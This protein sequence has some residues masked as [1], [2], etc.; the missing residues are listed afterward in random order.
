MKNKTM[1]VNFNCLYFLGSLILSFSIYADEKKDLLMVYEE[2]VLNDPLLSSAR[3]LNQSTKELIDQGLSLFLPNINIDASYDKNDNKRKILT[4]GI[5]NDLLS[6]TSAN[7]ESYDYGVTITQPIFNYASYAKYKQNLIQSSLS[8]KQLIK[9]QQNLIF[10]VLNIYFETLMAMDNIQLLQA[11]YSAIKAQLA[12]ADA[13]FEL[14]LI[15]ITDV[16][17]A[18]TKEALLKI[19]KIDAIQKL[20][21]K[22]REIESITGILPGK[23][24]PLNSIITFTKLEN[25]AEEWVSMA[26]ENSLELQIKKDE[27][28]IAD[29]EI[30]IRSGD[31]YPTID[32]MARRSRDWSKGGFPYGS[33]ANKGIR[34]FSDTI[35]LEVNIPIYS[36]GYASSRVREGKLLKLK[37]KEDEEYLRRQIELQV[38][39]NYLNLQSNYAEIGAYQQALSSAEITLDSTNL[40]FQVGLR[41]SVDVLRAQQVYFDAERDMLKARYN[42]LINQV[43][44]KQSVGM[45]TKTDLVVIN[46]YLITE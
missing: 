38:R 30:D 32:A 24:K 35:G 41:N 36:G 45:L 21:I 29:R 10:R 43:K 17:E 22:R 18:K 42:Y 5:N 31:R 44:L 7:F 20:K 26:L 14:G 28:R 40:G 46:K 27:V 2:A 13:R 12:Q 9:A 23:L 3:I 15:S 39:E 16:N 6:G 8:D 19:D 11:Q 4:S 1:L 25:Q 34:S 33:V 37:I